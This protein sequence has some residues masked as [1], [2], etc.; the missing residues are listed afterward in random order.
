MQLASASNDRLMLAPSTSRAPLLSVAEARSDPA[1]STMDSF[2]TRTTSFSPTALSL[3]ST[4]ICITACERLEVSFFLVGSTERFRFPRC[5]SCIVSSTVDVV[6]SV[7][8]A[9]QIPF[10]GSSRRS[11]FPVAGFSRSRMFSLYTS[12][13][14]R[15]TR[16]TLLS[17]DAR[18]LKSSP[19]VRTM[20]PGW[21]VLPSIVWVLPAPVAP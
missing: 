20:H 2:P 13:Y 3:P 21:S 4:M 10:T 7:M 12:R 8:P 17:C 11:R 19:T 1:R 6:N 5:S 16:Y 14:V 18:R 15:H 9:T